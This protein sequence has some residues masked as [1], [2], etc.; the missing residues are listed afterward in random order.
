[1]QGWGPAFGNPVA[2]CGLVGAAFENMDFRLYGPNEIPFSYSASDGAF[3][4]D[5]NVNGVSDTIDTRGGACLI[6]DIEID[7]DVTHYTIGDLAFSVIND[8]TG[9]GITLFD[10]PGWA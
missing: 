1:M 7:M 8:G 9:T 4:P 3:I 10:R 5:N 2:M 6:S